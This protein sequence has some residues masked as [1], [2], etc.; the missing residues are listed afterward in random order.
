MD[1]GCDGQYRQAKVRAYALG[2]EVS[3]R[4]REVTD[5]GEKTVGAKTPAGP[6]NGICVQAGTPFPLLGVGPAN[7]LNQQEL[8]THRAPT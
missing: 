8:Q 7:P 1:R 5:E 3:R 6:I 4:T 2:D